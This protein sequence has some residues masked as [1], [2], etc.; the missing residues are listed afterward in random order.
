MQPLLEVWIW[1]RLRVHIKKNTSD[2][3]NL[4]LQHTTFVHDQIMSLAAH[5]AYLWHLLE[6]NV[7]FY[8]T[9]FIHVIAMVL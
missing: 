3:C 1:Q 9:R 5:T 2:T 7:T 4:N 8:V 6:N